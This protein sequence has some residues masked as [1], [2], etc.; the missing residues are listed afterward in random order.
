VVGREI[1]QERGIVI[2]DQS[3]ANSAAMS[4]WIKSH[5]H[6]ARAKGPRNSAHKPTKSPVSAKRS[7]LTKS[8]PLSHRQHLLGQETV[9]PQRN[10]RI[11]VFANN[12]AAV[13]RGE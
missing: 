4:A 5:L 1:A 6:T 13:R 11:D 10:I 2:P 9:A 7:R 8:D 3:N 12:W